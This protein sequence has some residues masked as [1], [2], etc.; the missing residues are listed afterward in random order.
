MTASETVPRRASVSSP[1]PDRSAGTGR[2]L[3]VVL[4]VLTAVLWFD[5]VTKAWAWRTW[6][7]VQIDSGGGLFVGRPWG[8]V[9]ADPLAGPVL[10]LLACMLLVAVT[11]L[12]VRRRRTPLV[13]SGAALAIAGWTSD[14]ADRLGLHTWTA[15]GSSRGVVDFYNW[16]GRVW[17]LADAA[18]ALGTLLF[19]VG[20]LVSAL[21]RLL[22]AAPQA[23]RPPRPPY[24]ARL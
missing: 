4:G 19:A 1:V 22:T 13:L 21:R 18:I 8:A 7:H 20:V 14:L 24:A 6:Q 9:W 3:A 11:L 15:P 5:Q 12:V 16:N 10:D 17:N 2:R 23:P